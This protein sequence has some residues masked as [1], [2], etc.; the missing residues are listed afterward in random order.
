ML[1]PVYDCTKNAWFGAKLGGTDP[2]GKNAFDVSMALVYDPN[3][4]LVWTVDANGQ[5]SVLRFA[6]KTADL[7]DL[8]QLPAPSDAPKAQ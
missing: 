2:M 7:A 4:R 8:N 6:P 3:R 1:W 5:L